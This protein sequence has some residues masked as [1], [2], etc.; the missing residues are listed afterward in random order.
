[1]QCMHSSSVVLSVCVTATSAIGSGLLLQ[2]QQQQ[3][4]QQ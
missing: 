3:Q 1:L 2:R 4:Q